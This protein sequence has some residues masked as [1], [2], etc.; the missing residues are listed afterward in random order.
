[1]GDPPPAPGAGVVTE[2]V[3]AGRVE[4]VQPAAHRVLMAADPGRDRRNTQ[5]VPAQ[6]DDPG[7][8]APVRRGMPGARE[9]ADLPG[10]SIILRWARSQELW[11]GYW[12]P[13]TWPTLPLPTINY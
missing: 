5:P 8:L 12:P 1:L 7:P 9:P 10:L 2:P 3:Q 6:R 4:P 13:H 11:H